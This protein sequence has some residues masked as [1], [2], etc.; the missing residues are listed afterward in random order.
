MQRLTS[1]EEQCARDLLETVP[2]VMRIIRKQVRKHGA[3]TL[4]VPQFRTLSFVN[5]RKGASLSEVADHIGLTLP[6]MS[7]LV[8]GLVTHGYITRKTQ[9][10][11]RRKMNLMLTERGEKML[12]VAREGAITELSERLKRIQPNERATILRAMRI[13]REVFPEEKL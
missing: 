9:R 4:S 8:D 10:E 1:Q 3:S 7:G 11:D 12:Q 2:I 6:S 5:R 13:L